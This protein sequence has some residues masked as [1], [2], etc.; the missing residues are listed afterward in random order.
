MTPPRLGFT[1]V[2]SCL[3]LG[4]AACRATDAAKATPAATSAEP[5]P[6]PQTVRLTPSQVGQLHI[7]QLAPGAPTQAI[8]A[9]GAVEFDGD[10]VAR[11]LPPVPGQVQELRLNAGDSVRKGDVLFML[12]SREVASAIADHVAAHKDADL[13]EKTF[14]MTQDLFDHQAGSRMSLRQSEND[15]AKARDKVLQT[16][17]VLRVLGLEVEALEDPFRLQSRIAVRAPID[18]T[19]TERAVTNGQFV[20]PDN[21]LLVVADL[22][23][24]WVLA[25]VFE[26]DLHAIA[27]GQKADV[28]TAAYPD[29]QFNAEVAKIGTVV[30]AQTRT[31][32]VRFLVTNPGLRLK[33]GMFA[34]VNLYLKDTGRP[35]TAPA[36]AV[37][38]EGGRSFA[39]V[40]V[41][42][43]EFARKQV[44]ASPTASAR[45][46]VISG[47]AA[48]DRV[49][50]DG[51]L[52]LRQLET[53]SSPQ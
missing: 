31:A 2:L 11:I 34:S 17:E 15:V 3:A 28:T 42:D 4:M 37:F 9:T 43:R 40:Q 24:V 21:A 30:D 46:R 48:G 53:D 18:G 27:A 44:E 33:P 25:D 12:S 38:V 49:V 8:H 19:I 39:Y 29:Q 16:E 36:A 22:A 13:A 5:T 23:R 51:V 7:E 47:L 50:S 41:N 52:L 10:R 45:L 26:R 32:K 35:L 20:G 14:A 1:V 6:S